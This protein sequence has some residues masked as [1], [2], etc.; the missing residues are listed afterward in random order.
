MPGDPTES[1]TIAAAYAALI[2]VERLAALLPLAPG[3]TDRLDLA[4]VL[5][6]RQERSRELLER[7]READGTG[8]EAAV[9]ALAELTAPIDDARSRVESSDWWEA[10][11][12]TALSAPLTDELFAALLSDPAAGTDGNASAAWAAQRLRNALRED[13][14]LASR[15]AMWGRRLVG[16]VIMLAREFGGEEYPQLADRLAASHARRLADLELAG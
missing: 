11:T 15:I 3:L 6:Q 5:A 13:P 12:V 4:A 16:E 9:T 1:R 7:L 10:L 14:V 2:E 8:P